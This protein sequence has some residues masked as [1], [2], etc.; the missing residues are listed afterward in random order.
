MIIGIIGD[1]FGVEGTQLPDSQYT[2]LS[3]TLVSGFLC[4]IAER[5]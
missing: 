3:L 1:R 5:R 2:S 4:S